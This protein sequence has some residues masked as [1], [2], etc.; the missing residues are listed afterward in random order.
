[1]HPSA[2]TPRQPG[3]AAPLGEGRRPP[4]FSYGVIGLSVAVYVASMLLFQGNHP[5]LLYGPWVREG[6]WWRALSSVFEHGGVLHLVLNMSVVWTLGRVYEREIGTLAFAEISLVT[7]LGSAA[8]VLFWAFDQS[9]LGASGMIVGWVGAVLPVATRAHRRDLVTWLVQIA[10]ISAL[11]GVSWQGHLGGFLAG[12]PCGFA[13][14]AGRKTFHLAIPVLVAA[15]A[16]LIYWA[17]SRGI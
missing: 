13:L 7:A 16:A 17:A 2:P 12:L 4:Y 15:M 9:T 1:L 5:F 11:P 6:E 10:I 14:K 3:R 8:A